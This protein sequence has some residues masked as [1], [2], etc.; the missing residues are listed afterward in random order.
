MAKRKKGL[1]LSKAAKKS[2]QESVRHNVAQFRAR[3]S[4]EDAGNR[5]ET[6]RLSKAQTRALES[7]EDA[8]KPNPES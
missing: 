1:G 3:Q 2:R 4:Q 7:Q 8:E 5:R 6:D